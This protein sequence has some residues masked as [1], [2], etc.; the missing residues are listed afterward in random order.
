MIVNVVESTPCN[1]PEN[2][3][4][5]MYWCL[6][7]DGDWQKM[8]IT[9]H[10]VNAVIQRY[11]DSGFGVL[12]NNA[13]SSYTLTNV[14]P[15]SIPNSILLPTAKIPNWVKGVFGMYAD[16]KLSDADLI[17]A[18]QFLIKQGIIKLS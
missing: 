13:G 16:G 6:P 2:Q 3:L 14:E 8:S 11:T 15:V 4:S 17:Q 1:S 10:D 9:N 7:I 12:N 18:L 5:I